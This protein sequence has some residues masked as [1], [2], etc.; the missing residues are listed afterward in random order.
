MEMMWTARKPR[1]VAAALTLWVGSGCGESGEVGS[2]SKSRERVVNGEDDRRQWFELSSV[3]Q[4]DALSAGVAALMWAH[5]LD[6][7][8]GG[9]LRA[10]TLAQATGVCADEPFANEPSAAWCSATLI[11][12]DLVLT[13]GHCVGRDAADVDQACRQLRVVFDYH[14]A[15]P[16]E[17][18]LDGAED[19]YSCRRVVHR[20]YA[21]GAD[22]FR[23]LA[24]VQLDRAVAAE[25]RPIRVAIA[26]VDI[27]DSV[28]SATHGA[29]LPLKIDAGGVVTEVPERGEHFVAS[30]DSFAGGSGGPVFD[31]AM[32][33][34]AHQVK[35][36]PDWE[37]E[38]D[39]R[40]RAHAERAAEQHQ[41]A[42]RSVA[43]LCERGWPSERL[44]GRAA[45]CG[46]GTCSGGE[47]SATCDRD[48]APPLCG[49]GLCEG[50]EHADCAPDCAPYPDVPPTWL[51][52]PATYSSSDVGSERPLA[53]HAG[54]EPAG[55]CSIERGGLHSRGGFT[56]G[57]LALGCVLFRR[58]LTRRAL[59]N[60]ARRTGCCR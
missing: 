2:S 36:L 43:A 33:L 27:G 18:A 26:R 46:D 1:A 12:E 16:F 13:A 35:G 55:G 30:T 41:W 5:R 25:R 54:S 53:P 32:E 45:L 23:D 44:C 47:N 60:C 17:L 58:R 40:R 6:F 19:V 59:P 51:A 11:D 57:W 37:S 4:R 22:G 31:S 24:I 7:A 38:G 8:Q 56:C 28:L 10:V 9:L 39:C 50:G 20:E 3:D 15:R 49:D 52:A 29:G 42:A 34:V 48:C 14:Y 21:P